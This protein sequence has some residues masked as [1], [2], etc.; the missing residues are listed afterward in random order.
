MFSLFKPIYGFMFLIL[1]NADFCS[2]F[3]GTLL[4]FDDYVSKSVYILSTNVKLGVVIKTLTILH[5][6]TD[7]V[8]EDVIELY[9][10]PISSIANAMLTC[11][12]Q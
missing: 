3:A 5:C 7:M 8:L 10:V 11:S 4:G 9:V 12:S 2:E 6:F 1:Q